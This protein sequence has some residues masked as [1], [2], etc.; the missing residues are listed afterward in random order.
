MSVDMSAD[1]SV[2][3]LA[4]MSVDISAGRL[5]DMWAGVSGERKCNKIAIIIIK[6]NKN[7]NNTKKFRK[8]RYKNGVSRNIHIGRG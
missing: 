6:N 8:A 3:R 2:D 7:E 1:M 5:I 4:G